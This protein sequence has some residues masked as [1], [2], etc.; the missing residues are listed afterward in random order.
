MP[1]D[2]EYAILG[3]PNRARIGQ[4]LGVLASA[5]SAGM[6]AVVLAL[7][8][9]AIWL[10][11]GDAIPPVVLI[12]IGAGA[13]YAVLYW[14]FDTRVWKLGAIARWSRVPNLSGRWQCKGKTLPANGNPARSWRGEIVIVQSWDRI[15]V[16]LKTA[17]SSSSSMTA[18]LLHDAADGY[19]LIYSYRN[20]P[21]IGETELSSHLGFAELL[22]PPDLSSAEGEYF[23]GHGRYTFGTLLLA[24]EKG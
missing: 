19:R 16:R 11:V 15:R 2:H 22:F 3:G 24:K 6:V 21:K 1:Q 23:N 8:N 4:T 18:S 7:F 14:F 5:I 13:V 17:Q 12:P 9:V 20:D 10:G